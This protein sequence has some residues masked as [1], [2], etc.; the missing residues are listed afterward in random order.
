MTSCWALE[1]RY[2]YH[3]F[4]FL[5]IDNTKWSLGEKHTDEILVLTAVASLVPKTRV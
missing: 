2:M 1:H 3:I 4:S 5:C